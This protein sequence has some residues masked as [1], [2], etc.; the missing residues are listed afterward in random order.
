MAV[1]GQ[2]M[3]VPWT[4]YGGPWR[5]HGGPWRVHGGSINSLWLVHGQSMVGP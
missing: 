2:S 3:V 4:V 1:D 5:L